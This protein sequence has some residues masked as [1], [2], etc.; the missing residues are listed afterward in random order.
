MQRL[1]FDCSRSLLA[2][3]A[4]AAA[5]F[6]GM[7][8][9][10]QT[11]PHDPGLRLGNQPQ[12]GAGNAL[13][14]LEVTRDDDFQFWLAGLAM[15][16]RE[17]LVPGTLIVNPNTD[18][19]QS[20]PGL[21][22]A[23]NEVSCLNCH[24]QPKIGGT[25]PAANPQIA[26]AQSHPA[27]PTH[28]PNPEDLSAF[29]KPDGPIREARF[30]L[31]TDADGNVLNELDGGVHELFTIQGRKDAPTGCSL[32]Q[33]NFAQQITNNNV[34]FRIPTPTF[35]V[36]FIENT[37]DA[38]LQANLAANA[39][40]ANPLGIF[41]RFNTSG[42]DGTITKFG[43]KAQNKSL[44]IFAGEAMNV[45]MGITNESFTNEKVPGTN[46][47]TNNLPEDLTRIIPLATL[48]GEPTAG[49]ATSVV[50]SIAV[51][52][53]EFMRLNG[54][55]IQ[56]NYNQ[57]GGTCQPLDAHAQHGQD[58]FESIHCDLCHT[59]I[60]ITDPSRFTDL[61]SAP[62]APFSDFALHHMGANLAD[63]ISQGQA[64]PDEFRTAPLWG[65]GQRIFFLHDGRTKDLIEAIQA[66]ADDGTV[67]FDT[68]S[69]Q[70]FTVKFVVLGG[71]SALFSPASSTH[72]CGSEA[73]QVIAQ[74]NSMLN[75]SPADQASIQDLLDFLRS[76]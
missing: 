46:C 64:G 32:N 49:N 62:F 20:L 70:S 1:L 72:Q 30:I 51:N 76:L 2:G 37:S 10:A 50:S 36:G 18:V 48:A 31:Q 23:F 45:E 41:G 19:L 21:G 15:F 12:G 6:C 74:F 65:L 59:P 25:S 44:D 9:Q 3:L 55:A 75:G 66:H 42:N 69:T 71:N 16:G 35:G 28:P 63:G 39:A 58:V 33:P 24:S 38:T 56:C 8:L 27:D 73:N 17:A 68:N 5:L 11:P 4:I 52:F 54:A 40:V 67:C 34:I 13:P 7:P 57:N 29:I 47:A 22:P 26:D 60:L 61:N 53:G 43:W 14:T